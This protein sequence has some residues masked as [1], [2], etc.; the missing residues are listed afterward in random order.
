MK[1]GLLPANTCKHSAEKALK[2]KPLKQRFRNKRVFLGLALNAQAQMKFFPK[3]NPCQLTAV[4]KEVQTP[5]YREATEWEYQAQML[6]IQ[7]K[8]K[9]C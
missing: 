2:Y 4:N 1:I 7:R 5:S 3:G 8:V 6:K 9:Q